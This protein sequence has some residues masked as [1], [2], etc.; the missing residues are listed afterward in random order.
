[1]EGIDG[2]HF[3]EFYFV[4]IKSVNKFLLSPSGRGEGVGLLKSYL[5]A[6][7]KEY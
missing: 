1:M 2:N 4:R 5:L 7:F 3:F 6:D